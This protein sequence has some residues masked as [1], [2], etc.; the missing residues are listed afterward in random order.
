MNSTSGD[1]GSSFG[2]AIGV[3]L[4]TVGGNVGAALVTLI[5]GILTLLVAWIPPRGHWSNRVFRLWAR[6]VLL[7]SGVRVRAERD[8]EPQEG[9][10][11][12]YMANHLS[13]Y[14]IPALLVTLPGD[15]RFL[16]KKSLFRIPVAGW[17]LAADGAIAVDRRDRSRARETF[18]AAVERLREGASVVIFPEE[19]RSLDGRVHEFRSGGVLLALRSGLS[20]VPVG[21]EGTLEVRP[22]GSL[23]V[24]PGRVV[25]RYG[26]PVPV[27]GESVRRKGDLAEELRRRVAQLART[28]LS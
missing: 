11:F 21:I 24:R 3:A 15:V 5:F 1:S 17:A 6:T 7:L 14:D 20:V 10:H 18:M 28:E 8:S 25:V 2:S 27:A 13:G 26:R 9:E 16:A 4:A 22:K 12:I 23:L 19:T